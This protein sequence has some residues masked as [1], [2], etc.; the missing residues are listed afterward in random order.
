MAEA[1]EPVPGLETAR[2]Q[3]VGMSLDELGN[4]PEIDDTMTFV[5]QAIC[6]ARVLR[7]MKDGE[8]RRTAILRVTEVAAQGDPIKPD[9][10]PAGPSL[11][12]VEDPGEDEDGPQ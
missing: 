2:V 3:F 6:E 11:W 8:Y 7:R 12:P 5:V 9:P 10:K 4:P 1:Q